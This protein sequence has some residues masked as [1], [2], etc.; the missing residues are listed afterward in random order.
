MP[1][2]YTGETLL[3]QD[4]NLKSL[5]KIKNIIWNLKKHDKLS[6]YIVLVFL[7]MEVLMKRICFLA[8][9]CL[10]L[11]VSLFAQDA[12]PRPQI[13][14]FDIATSSY[15]P[16]KS[17][18]LTDVFRAEL[19]KT[20]L[21]SIIEKGVVIEAGISGKLPAPDKA[22]DA[23]LLQIG[24]AVKCDKLFICSVE[25]IATTIAISVRVVDVKTSLIDYT[26]NVFVVNES[27][28]FDALKEIA[29]KI[30]F[31]YTEGKRSADP[32][33]G[34]AERWAMLGADE[35]SAAY[36]VAARIDPE[37]YL[38]IRQYDI[39]F[40]PEQYVAILQSNIDPAIVKTFLQSGIS[41]AQTE[42]ALALGITKLD[43]YREVFLKAGY[44]FED[45]LL[46]F[47]KNIMSI[48]EYAD[49]KRGYNTNYFNFGAGGVADSFP[50]ANAS[51]KF[52]LLKAS[53]ERFWTPYQRDFFK[54]STDAGLFLMS[55]FA[56][57]PFFQANAYLGTYPY[58][59]KISLGGHAEVILGGH[60]GA[61]AQLGFEIL[62][63]LDFSAM[64]V[65]AGTQPK[66]SY[67]GLMIRE[68]EPGY[69]KIIF[70]YAG[71]VVSYKLPANF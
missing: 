8:L 48:K 14:I 35:K 28:I 10:F 2:N 25:K 27:Q 4:L 39:T 63:V 66:V 44:G 33:S 57:V 55:L 31:F 9:M 65:F 56:P 19:F 67:D 59:L 13:I 62:E 37:V 61:Y 17:R 1:E 53:W 45:Y 52:L 32:A 3:K 11:L 47:S 41:Y 26:D 5:Y 40:K 64:L 50:I 7:I 15:D 54:V 60:V 6:P 34:L 69:S 22:D 49:Y 12:Q 70:P 16:G 68:G 18:L 30:E 71:F 43:R 29:T 36:L 42:R 46:A 24:R 51:Y 38:S 23:Q 58:Y 21:F 20:R